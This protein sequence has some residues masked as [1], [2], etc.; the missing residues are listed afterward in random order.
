MTLKFKNVF[1][2]LAA[3]F[4]INGL[5][6]GIEAQ[7]GTITEQFDTPDYTYLNVRT[8][9][10][11]QWMAIAKRDIS[12]G[13]SIQF[14]GGVPMTDF[15]SKSLDRTFESI[16]FVSNLTVDSSDSAKPAEAESFHSPDAL[17]SPRTAAAPSKSEIA[18]LDGGRTVDELLRNATNL[19]GETVS[20]R[21]KVTKVSANIMGNTWVTLQ[22]GTGESPNDKLLATTQETVTPGETVVVTGTVA[23]DVDLGYGYEYKVLLEE[24]RFTR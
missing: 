22:D 10:G 7:Q 1:T 4:C 23:T 13:D 18:P 24:A 21:A 14:S 6:A 12:V 17:M 8:E 19:S 11:E 5:A 15:Y 9:A 3:S 16:L 2:V 20:L